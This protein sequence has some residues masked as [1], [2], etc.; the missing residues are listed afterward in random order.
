MR[1]V[2]QAFRI[3]ETLGKTRSLSSR[4]NP[5]IKAL[6]ALATDA[7]EA[8]RQGRTLLDG[9]HLVDAYRRRI[10][11]P[12]LLLVSDSGAGHPEV[13]RLL[14]ELGAVE[15][16]HVTD[17]LF[18][19]ISG[20]GTPVGILA[21]IALP[22]PA[23]WCA[24]GHCVM[25]DAVQD[26]GNVGAILRTAAAAGVTDVLLGAGCAGAWTPRV[27]RAGQGAHFSL[28]IHD[29]ADLADALRRYR[30]SSVAAV[31]HGGTCLFDLDL[32]GDIGWV[33]G[34]E[35]AGI[36]PHLLAGVSRRATIPVATDTESL[37]VAAAAAICLF[38]GL[39]RG[40]A[41]RG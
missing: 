13:A 27:L 9:P 4:D 19:E 36:D 11:L 22:D 8:R 32:A 29:Q 16:L 35:G 23:A 5:V 12:E 31:A 3:E 25:L 2:R 34:N 1:V 7:R 28:R 14:A 6:R 37:N 18:R 39:R 40:R 30:G 38:E 26:A 21:A 24:Q 20:G 17:G 10:G 33:F 41:C 15:T